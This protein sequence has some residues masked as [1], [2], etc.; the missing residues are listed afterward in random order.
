MILGSIG[1][2][3]VS[4]SVVAAALSTEGPSWLYFIYPLVFTGGIIMVIA[5]V[6]A[7]IG[8]SNYG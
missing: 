6:I 7:W 4:A 8:S 3:L 1:L 5:G 2:V